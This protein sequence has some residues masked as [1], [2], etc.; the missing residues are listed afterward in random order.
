MASSFMAFLY[1]TQRRI[2]VGRTPPGVRSAQHTDLYLTTHNTHNR[3][4]SMPLEGFEP[5][6]QQAAAA[7]L[8][9]RPR[10]HLDRHVWV[11]SLT[12]NIYVYNVTNYMAQ[13]HFR[14]DISFAGQEI[15][16]FTESE[17]VLINRSH[18]APANCTNTLSA[19]YTVSDPNTRPILPPQP[20]SPM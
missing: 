11:H 20:A 3:Q 10:G 6:S 1:N 4:T 18:P 16:G 5:K 19:T 15:I 8:R 13:S 12:N 14:T 9:L 2:T 17:S 7:D